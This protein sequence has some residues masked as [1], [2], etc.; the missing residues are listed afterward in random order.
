VKAWTV[1]AGADGEN[2]DLGLKEGIV[3][4]GWSETADLTGI[5]REQLRAI[6]EEKHSDASPK[7]IINWTGQVWSFINGIQIGDLAILPLKRRAA[8]AI[9]RVESGYP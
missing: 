7:R 9:G 5:T 6:L 3:A 4:I 8:I 1:R 2:E